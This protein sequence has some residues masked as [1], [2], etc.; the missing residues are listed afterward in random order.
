MYP[1]VSL[2]IICYEMQREITRTLISLSPPYQSNCPPGRCEVIVID[3]GSQIPPKMEDFSNLSVNLRIIAWPKGNPSPVEAIN[4]GLSLATAPLIGVWIDGARMA[5]PGL[6]DACIQASKLHARAVVA[7][8]NYHLGPALQH[9]SINT[10][11]NAQQEDDLLDGIS[12][13][14][15]GYQLFNI[16]TPE[17]QGGDTGPM[18]ESNALFLRKELWEEL[19][20][21]DVRYDEPGGGAVN[22]DTFVRACELEDSQLIRVVGEGTFHQIH[23]GLTTS[24]GDKAAALLKHGSRKYLKIRNKP[25]ASVRKKGWLYNSR[26]RQVTV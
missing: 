5:S 17:R 4:H 12:W 8:F 19:G 20:G 1:E 9:T 22:P 6:V 24:S 10:G 15:D 25:L 3:N 13:P 7:T 26:T 11:Y 18:L 14:Q 21:Y 2:V 16:S 23:G